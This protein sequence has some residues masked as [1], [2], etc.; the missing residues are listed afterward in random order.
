MIDRY[1]VMG[2]PVAH[3]KS[4]FIH[5][6]FAKQTAQA[7][8]YEKLLVEPDGFE[9]ALRRFA[10]EGGKGLNITVPFKEH[11]YRITATHSARAE[12]A[13]AVNTLKIETGGVW[14]GDNTDGEGLVRDLLRDPEC[15]LRGGRVLV[16][17]AGGAVRGVLGPL[18][19]Q[20][21]GALTLAN[22]TVGKAVALA[23]GFAGKVSLSAAG[24]DALAGQRFDLVINGTAAS[25]QGELPPLPDGI[26]APGAWCYD[27][28]YGAEP[29]PFLR[30]AQQ[31]GAARTLDGLGMLVEQAAE[32]FRV[33]RGVRP[34]TAPVIADLRAALG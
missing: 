34:E 2:N 32:S 25:L 1:A 8:S 13:H 10:A 4:P 27:M 7:L 19:D 6:A 24:Y 20:E 26:L 21:P 18:L 12:R 22:R 33:W 5:A 17:G 30:W 28:M 9:A 29:T 15:P 16:L 11:A 31:R 3:S 23:E 14:F